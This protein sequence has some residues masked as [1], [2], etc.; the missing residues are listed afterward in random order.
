LVGA[1]IRFP[2]GALQTVAP[3][4]F[5]FGQPG[6]EQTPEA[7]PVTHMQRAVTVRALIRL[8]RG[9]RTVKVEEIHSR[10]VKPRGAPERYTVHKHFY[11][12]WRA[13]FPKKLR[14][15]KKSRFYTVVPVTI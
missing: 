11:G 2:K 9:K 8:M 1:I 15:R 5:I 14:R 10:K 7:K 4:V 6:L 12:N 13:K 3:G